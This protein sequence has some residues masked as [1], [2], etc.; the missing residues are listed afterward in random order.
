MVQ[1]IYTKKRRLYL[2]L[3]PNHVCVCLDYYW[4][5]AVHRNAAPS[6]VS[7]DG[8]NRGT[9]NPDWY[10]LA[11]EPSPCQIQREHHTIQPAHVRPSCFYLLYTT[12]T[13][14]TSKSVL[15]DS[16]IE[17][18]NKLIKLYFIFF[19]IVHT[20]SLVIGI[21]IFNSSNRNRHITY[22]S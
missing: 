17:L 15:L 2:H 22:Q 19:P 16:T 9:G 12:R 8:T 1:I 21:F 11:A 6:E 18:E 10:F 14:W 7:T 13:T 4:V 3:Y 5:L 20:L